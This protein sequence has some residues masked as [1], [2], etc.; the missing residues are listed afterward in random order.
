MRICVVFLTGGAIGNLIDRIFRGEQL[1][2]G[3]VVDM[4]YVELINFPVF[5]VA[6]SFVSVGFVILVVMMFIMK[7]DDLAWLK[8]KRKEKDKNENN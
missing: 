6:D 5:N 7:D 1:F 3:S 8:I 4:I 2:H